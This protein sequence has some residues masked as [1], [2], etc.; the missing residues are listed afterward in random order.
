MNLVPKEYELCYDFIEVYLI[1]NVLVSG[2]QQN[3]SIIH[4]YSCSCCFPFW[5]IAGC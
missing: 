1:Y 4:M 2:I 5:F 3:D